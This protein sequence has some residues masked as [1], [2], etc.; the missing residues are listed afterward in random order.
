MFDDE[1]V[2]AI[3][4][5]H[6]WHDPLSHAGGSRKFDNTYQTFRYELNDFKEKARVLKNGGFCIEFSP[7]GNSNNWKHLFSIKE[8]T[9]KCGLSYYAKVTWVKG[10]SRR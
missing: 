9:E 4:N 5:D 1:A 3:I 2:D 6:L 10:I 8:M 7:A